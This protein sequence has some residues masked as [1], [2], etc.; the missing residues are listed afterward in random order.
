M[1]SVSPVKARTKYLPNIKS[2]SSTLN[3]ICCGRRCV[4]RLHRHTAL[5]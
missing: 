1:I 3:W 2:D 5:Y 4:R